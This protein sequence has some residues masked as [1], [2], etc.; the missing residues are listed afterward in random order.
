MKGFKKAIQIKADFTTTTPLMIRSGYEGEFTD[1][2]I[3]RTPEGK[4]HING[5]VW[6]S[7]IRRALGRIKDVGDLAL[8]IGNYEECGVSPLWT[9]AS[10]LNTNVTDVRPGNRIDRSYGITIKGALFS[11]EIA[12][13]GLKGALHF[14][15]FAKDDNGLNLYKN[16]VL[17]AL[18]VINTGIENIGAGWSYGFG[19]L[20]FDK[21]LGRMIDIS[22]QPLWD[23]QSKDFEELKIPQVAEI[24]IACPWVR[25]EVNACISE[26]QMLAVHTKEPSQSIYAE[27]PDTFVYMGHVIRD[28]NLEHRYIIPGRTIRQA[29]F[30]VPIE[31]RLRSIGQDCCMEAGAVKEGCNCQRCKW[32]GSSEAGGIIAVTDA[33]VEDPESQV[34]HRIQLDE[35]SMQNINLFSSEYLSKGSFTFELIIDMAREGAEALKAEIERLLLEMKG[36]NNC[37]PGWHRLGATST[38]TGQIRVKSF[39]GDRFYGG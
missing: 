4:I 38:C 6:S 31:R 16:Q 14:T 11:D 8:A 22:K 15:L 1:S 33:V 25:Y 37:P 7:L 28:G 30:S 3:D 5:Y 27:L 35:H 2:S 20:K 26:G 21:V 12:P 24:D 19:R 34:L 10:F 29:L 13:S 18:T 36:Q 32:F 23:W 39:E 17:S 9:E